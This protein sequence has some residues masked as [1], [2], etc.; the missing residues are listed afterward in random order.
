MGKRRG[1]DRAWLVLPGHPVRYQNFSHSGEFRFKYDDWYALLK[2]NMLILTFLH[3]GFIHSHYQYVRLRQDHTQ[4][5]LGTLGDLGDLAI[6][7]AACV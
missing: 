6:C 3:S 2:F 7:Q 1:P 4:V 5:G